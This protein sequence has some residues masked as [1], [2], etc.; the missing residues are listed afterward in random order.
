MDMHQYTFTMGIPNIVMHLRSISTKKGRRLFIKKREKK[1][2]KCF[3]SKGNKEERI[4][5]GI[6]REG[7]R[8]LSCWNRIRSGSN[9]WEIPNSILLW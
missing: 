7:T 3:Y 5:E 1:K 8:G 6:K 4:D 2:K 9:A